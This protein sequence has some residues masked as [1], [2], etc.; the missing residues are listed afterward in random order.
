MAFLYFHLARLCGWHKSLFQ[1]GDAEDGIFIAGHTSEEDRFLQTNRAGKVTVI[2]GFG[3]DFVEEI[4]Y[5]LS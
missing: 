1:Y 3:V 4:L 5:S 2:E